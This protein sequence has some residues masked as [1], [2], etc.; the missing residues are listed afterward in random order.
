[1]FKRVVILHIS[2]QL[3]VPNFILISS[4]TLFWIW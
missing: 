4:I 1:L 2:E 3:L